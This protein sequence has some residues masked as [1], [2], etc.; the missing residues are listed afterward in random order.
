MHKIA[1][2][3]KRTIPPPLKQ[4]SRT[5]EEIREAVR[6]VMAERDA[7]AWTKVRWSPDPE[8]VTIVADRPSEADSDSSDN[9]PDN[10]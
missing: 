10:Q 2:M 6:K 1:G 5:P 9:E 7:A 3:S 8:P 4:G